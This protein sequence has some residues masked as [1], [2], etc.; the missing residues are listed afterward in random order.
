MALAEKVAA[1]CSVLAFM[2]GVGAQ[3]GAAASGGVS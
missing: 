3:T 2:E 1:R